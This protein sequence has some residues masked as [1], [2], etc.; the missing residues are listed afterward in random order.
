M[1]LGSLFSLNMLAWTRM[2]G[3]VGHKKVCDKVARVVEL[4]RHDIVWFPIFHFTPP[5]PPAPSRDFCNVPFTSANG[6]RLFVSHG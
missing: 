5:T 4:S 6:W 2:K 1:L 3:P